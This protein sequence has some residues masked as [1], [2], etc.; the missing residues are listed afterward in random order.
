M[1]QSQEEGILES[2]IDG[3]GTNSENRNIKDF[4]KGRNEHKEG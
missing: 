1:C 3:L 4:H 2:Q